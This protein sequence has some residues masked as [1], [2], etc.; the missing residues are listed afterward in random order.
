[1]ASAPRPPSQHRQFLHGRLLKEDISFHGVI[2]RSAP[3]VLQQLVE[4]C[5]WLQLTCVVLNLECDDIVMS[6]L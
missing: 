2:V 4:F 6:N 3:V 5:P 1:M